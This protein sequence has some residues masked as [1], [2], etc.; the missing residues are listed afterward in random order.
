MYVPAR[1]GVSGTLTDSLKIT[2]VVFAGMAVLA[3]WFI[4]SPPAAKR[5]A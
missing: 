3:L 1:I 4:V 2:G 5:S